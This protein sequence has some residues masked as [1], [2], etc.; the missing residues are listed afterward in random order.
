MGSAFF[1]AEDPA[2]ELLAARE[3]YASRAHSSAH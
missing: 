3:A 1:S 2:K